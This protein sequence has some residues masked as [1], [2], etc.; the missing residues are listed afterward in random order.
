[1]KIIIRNTNHFFFIVLLSSLFMRKLL[2]KKKKIF[3][4]SHLNIHEKGV[5]NYTPNCVTHTHTP[6]NF[7]NMDSFFRTTTK[8]NLFNTRCMIMTTMTTMMMMMMA[9]ARKQK[10]NLTDNNRLL[11]RDHSILFPTKRKD[12]KKNSETSKLVKFFK[13]Q[14]SITKQENGRN[15]FLFCFLNSG[16]LNFFSHVFFQSNNNNDSSQIQ[17]EI[18]VCVFWTKS[19]IQ[20]FYKTIII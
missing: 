6:G 20:A 18:C 5:K 14:V 9:K 19:S 8:I 7:Q 10:K 3:F 12:K 13:F 2:W 16:Y 1:M 11:I 17:I 4:S 15:F